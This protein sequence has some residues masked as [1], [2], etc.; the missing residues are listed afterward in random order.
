CFMVACAGT[1]FAQSSD[2]YSRIN[3]L[4]Q[5]MTAGT[6]TRDQQLELARLY[7]ESG[8]F[9][10]ASKI[11]SRVAADN[12]NDTDAK[13]VRDQA[14][15]GLRD[16]SDKAIADAEGRAN[17]AGATD[18]DRLVLAN[19]YFEGGNY[20]AAGDAYAKLPASMLDYGTSLR[21]A[22]AL[23]WSGQMDAAEREYA[24][25]LRQQSSPEVELEYGRLL[26]WMGATRPS[27]EALT[28]VYRTT[29]NEDNA[30]ALAN[31]EAWGGRRDDAIVLLTDFTSSNA[32]APQARQ[33]LDQM[34]QSPEVR[35][36]RVNKLIDLEP[37]NLAL[38][39]EKARLLAAAGR[40]SEALTT[41][42]FVR[43][44]A[45]ADIAGLDEI[46]QQA[47]AHRQE[48]L[49]KLAV[50]LKGV[51]TRNVQNADQVLSLAKAYTALG[52]YPNAIRL[53]EDY[54][55]ARPDDTNARIAY[56]RV[57]NW[58][59][60]YTA[61]ERQY[62]QLIDANPDR[63]DL[64]YEYAEVL[65]YESNFAQ[66]LHMFS[67][68]TDLSQNPRANLYSDVPPKAHFNRGQIY[69]W[70]GWNEHAAF[71]QN[72]AIALD[73]SYL[74]ARQELDLVRHVR[75]T[76]TLGGQYSY[77]TDSNRFTMKRYDLSAAKWTSQRTSWDLGLGR[78]NFDYRGD[79]VNA[80]VASFGGAYRW[81]DRSTV[82]AR[83]GLNF[84]ERG[85]GTRPFFG[86][87]AEWLPSIQSR[88]ALDFNH[89]DLVYDVFTIQSLTNDPGVG[90]TFNSFRDPIS[91][92]DVRGHYDYNTGGH[93]S[94]L[95]DA[96]HGFVS[97]NNKRDALHGLLTYRIT[98]AP[99]IAVKAEGRYLSYDFRTNRY[100]SPPD[101][102]SFAG[103][104]QIGQN[105]R[106]R[107]FWNIEGK[108]GKAYEGNTT[109]DLRSYEGNV[110]VPVND[111]IDIIGNY[112]YGKSG[113]LD[114]LVGSNVND[115]VNYWQRHWFVGVR[116]K[117]LLSRDERRATGPTPYYYD[118][119]PLTG[120]PVV[121]PLGEAH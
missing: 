57:L 9:Y 60:R 113:R 121:P 70:F 24:Q 6:A 96:S 49:A 83:V 28:R 120:S 106:E 18:Q 29:P 81:S 111:L 115:F 8:R 64:R 1:A 82:R 16:I 44:H 71:E 15:R 107:L 32:N 2:L 109:S 61:A 10:E 30:V 93:W 99:F 76:S 92:N 47:R 77:A 58:D 73:G 12:P 54:L 17:A 69:R 118:N 45:P 65:S 41:V 3:P 67:G 40:D 80:N 34:R 37:F 53:Y 91:I 4:E 87:G 85:L 117:Q 48:E 100:W 43:E 35:L 97:D 7:I 101:Y 25:L 105:I 31:A 22:R 55:R 62:E 50:Q 78:H 110:T 33:L 51:D 59:R 27:I 13:A 112:G 68:L 75:P 84:Y 52:D 72:Q 26:S 5:A 23:A 102:R 19:A 38:Q 21:R 114:S 39:V 66:A 14:S 88:A 56:A 74:P 79:E 104:L 94:W 116:L 119:R 98:R 42:Q 63:A 36:E 46:E 89:Y 86:A 11:A 20:R 90:G 95:A 108:A 103:V